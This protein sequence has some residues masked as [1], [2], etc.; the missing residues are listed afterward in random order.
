MPITYETIATATV[1]ATS[2]AFTSIPSTYTDLKIIINGIGTSTG[3]QLELRVNNV[4]T[5]VYSW[6]G[7]RGFGAS[8]QSLNSNGMTEIYATD[9]GSGFSTTIPNTSIM[10]IF[11][12]TGSNFKTILQTVF[13]DKNGSGAVGSFV[14]MYRQTTAITSLNF[15]IGSGNFVGTATLY[16]IKA[17]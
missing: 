16:G 5:A 1:N 7:F 17:A 2:F 15:Y 10:D 14:W 13:N 11:S 9:T 12:Y 4:S 3:S 6:N 8:N